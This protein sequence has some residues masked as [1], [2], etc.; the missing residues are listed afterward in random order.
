MKRKENSVVNKGKNMQIQFQTLQ[1]Q[2]NKMFCLFLKKKLNI[3][4]NYKNIL[5]MLRINIFKD[6]F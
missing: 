2:L 6:V 1:A 4:E 3:K 5:N